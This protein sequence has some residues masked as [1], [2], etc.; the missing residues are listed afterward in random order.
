MPCLVSTNL[1]HFYL[2]ILL[3]FFFTYFAAT[4]L[5]VKGT[6]FYVEHEEL[7]L[8]VLRLFPPSSDDA[9]TWKKIIPDGRRDFSFVKA[10]SWL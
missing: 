6:F 3:K 8:Q 9:T 10:N 7:C 1:N 2:I 4:F 5:Y